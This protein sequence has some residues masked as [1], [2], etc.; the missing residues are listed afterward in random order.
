MSPSVAPHP[1]R[2]P[3]WC[4]SAAL[5]VTG[6][7]LTDLY[8]GRMLT[9]GILPMDADSISLPVLQRALVNLVA[10]PAILGLTWLAFRNYAR[11][12]G[13]LAWRSDRPMLSLAVSLPL[14]AA[15]VWIGAVTVADLLAARR[16]PIP[17]YGQ[18]QYLDPALI[19]AWLLT[20]RALMLSPR[21]TRPCGPPRSAGT[22][23]GSRR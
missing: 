21:L 10:A 14:V 11:W 3:F 7:V 1:R 22:P 2:W 18:I 13:L 4:L 20:L 23:P 6:P 5:I 12:G 17:W 16:E 8:W 9:S 15:A 19:L